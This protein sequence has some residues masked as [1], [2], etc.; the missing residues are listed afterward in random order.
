MQLIT[1]KAPPLQC[2]EIVSFSFSEGLIVNCCPM[3]GCSYVF[4]N[5]FN[6]QNHSVNIIFSNAKH[7]RVMRIQDR[8]NERML[9]LFQE[10]EISTNTLTFSTTIGPI[11][12]FCYNVDP[13]SFKGI[14]LRNI[15]NTL[16]KFQQKL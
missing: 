2:C 4:H 15:E 1:K 6:F 3:S 14:F 13:C 12:C 5:S 10:G 8:S 7:H 11:S 9:A 16:G